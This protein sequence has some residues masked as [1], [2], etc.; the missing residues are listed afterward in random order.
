M[1]SLP[2][3][4][5]EF[6]RARLVPELLVAEIGAS[7]RFWCELCGFRVVYDRMEEG[8]AYIDRDGAQVMLEEAGRGRNWVT[9]SLDLPLGRGI[10]FEIQVET[11]APILAA[12][13]Q[14]AWPLFMEPEEKWYRTGDAAAGV[15][16]FLVQDPDGYLLRFSQPLG[17]RVRS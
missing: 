1:T 15:R 8:F 17:N 6:G 9:A 14:A 5:S 10:N 4:A 12:L 2:S 7:L 11:I 16:Q 13:E 3:C